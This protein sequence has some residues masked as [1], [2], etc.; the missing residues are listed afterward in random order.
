[1]VPTDKG[2]SS[3]GADRNTCCL[4]QYDT[5][6]ELGR[7]GTGIVYLVRHKMLGV[8]RAVKCI[9]KNNP[10]HETFLQEGRI[11]QNLNHPGIPHIYDMQ[12]DEHAFYMIEE[13]VSG[14][15]LQTIR[16]AQKDFSQKTIIEYGIE[17]CEFLQYLHQQR[18]FPLLYLDLKP[19]HIILTHTGL[20]FVDFGSL[21]EGRQGY[22]GAGISGTR[23]FCAPEVEAGEIPEVKSDI[24]SVGAV[25]YY[26]HYGKIYSAEERESFSGKKNGLT[27]IMKKC[28]ASKEERYS[29]VKDLKQALISIQTEKE[30]KE[31]TSLNIAVLGT[32]RRVGATHFSIGLTSFLNQIG[33][34]ALYMEEGDSGVVDKILENTSAEE[35]AG[36]IQYKNFRGLPYYGPGIEKPGKDS[37]IVV[38]DFGYGWKESLKVMEQFDRIFVVAGDSCWDPVM[39]EIPKELIHGLPVQVV[40]PF[41]LSPN[42]KRILKNRGVKRCFVMP[43]F[44]DVWKLGMNTEQFYRR[45]WNCKV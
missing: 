9:S 26:L 7:G 35:W 30:Q 41:E 13:Y 10:D 8:L 20:K 44:Q 37:C 23:G 2:V 45:L 24:Y 14:Q 3:R 12:E 28:L 25:L 11:L 19:D 17:I 4:E 16:S 15:S 43:C 21:L 18:P 5:I 32:D 6:Q 38:H 22:A 33:K 29:N 31:Q 40:V 34:N 1:M 27:E 39:W 42:G 36:I